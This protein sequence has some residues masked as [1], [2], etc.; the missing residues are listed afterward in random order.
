MSALENL[1]EETWIPADRSQEWGRRTRI[2]GERQWLV[3]SEELARNEG[4][5]GLLLTAGSAGLELGRCGDRPTTNTPLGGEPDTALPCSERAGDWWHPTP[6]FLSER[7]RDPGQLLARLRAG[8][9]EGLGSDVQAMSLALDLLGTHQ[10]LPELRVALYRALRLLP[11][12]QV[13]DD[14]VDL[15][16]RPGIGLGLTGG[17]ERQEIVLDPVDGSFLGERIVLA[18]SG[19]GMWGGLPAGTVVQ[20]TSVRTTTVDRIGETSR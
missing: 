16:G 19:T 20:S 17:T 7:P 2:T 14:A 3:G 6:R 8:T 9:P 13:V 15:D 11:G 5:G 1:L 4:D 18:E 12:L 10:A